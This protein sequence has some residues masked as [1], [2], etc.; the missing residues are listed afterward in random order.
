MHSSDSVISQQKLSHSMR[1]PGLA[2]AG[3]SVLQTV[4]AA[5]AS[6]S[7]HGLRATKPID[8]SLLQSVDPVAVSMAACSPPGQPA[9][10]LCHSGPPKSLRQ[11]SGLNGGFRRR[12]VLRAGCTSRSGSRCRWR[13]F[14][15]ST[16]SRPC[17]QPHRG[18]RRGR[19]RMADHPTLLSLGAEFDKVNMGL[20]PGAPRSDASTYALPAASTGDPAPCLP[21]A[22][23]PCATHPTIGHRRHCI[24]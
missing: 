10:P 7:F 5:V 21:P 6:S 12:G 2:E 19:P 13:H 23:P 3:P 17:R 22:R 24:G 15:Q 18:L 4:L 9:L 11:R 14:R 20:R 8:V 1:V 16:H